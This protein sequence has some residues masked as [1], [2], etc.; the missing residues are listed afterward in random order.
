ML[1]NKNTI[2]YTNR[3]SQ[4]DGLNKFFKSWIVCCSDL[5]GCSCLTFGMASTA[6]LSWPLSNVSINF[7]RHDLRQGRLQ[8]T[9]KAHD[10]QSLI[11]LRDTN[12][13]CHG[14]N[15]LV[16]GLFNSISTTDYTLF[17][18]RTRS[19]E[20]SS[21]IDRWLVGKH[22]STPGFQN[23]DSCSMACIRKLKRSGF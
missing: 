16:C 5:T 12:V 18:Q 9:I 21:L 3:I 22:K 14:M 23:E 20:F 2:S 4:F 6:L 11:V 13:L 7:W 8:K 15:F 19:A 17:L 10:L 1:K